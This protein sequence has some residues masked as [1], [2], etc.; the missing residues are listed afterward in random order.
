MTITLNKKTFLNVAF[1]LFFISTFL[2]TYSAA[3][4]ITLVLFCVVAILMLR[5]IRMNSYLAFYMLFTAWCFLIIQQGYAIDVG[6]ATDMS[7]SPVF[8]KPYAISYA[9]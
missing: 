6:V 3:S 5:T 2:F 8:N 9:V 1:I 7:Q 4:R